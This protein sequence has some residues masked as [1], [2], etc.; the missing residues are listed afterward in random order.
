MIGIGTDICSVER[1]RKRL[2][3]SKRAIFLNKIFTEYEQNLGI[4]YKDSANFYAGRWAVKEAV[5]KCLKTG[6]GKSCHWLDI[7][8]KR[9]QKGEPCL[10]LEG[11]TAITAKNLGITNWHVSLSHEQSFAVA[12]VIAS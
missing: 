11:T 7:S 2:L 1:I 5:A 9:G 10:Y 6:F 12:F 8:V 4:S 3:S